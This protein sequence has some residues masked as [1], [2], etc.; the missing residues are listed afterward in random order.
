MI[1]PCTPSPVPLYE[2]T[3]QD[4]ATTSSSYE[5]LVAQCHRLVLD[6]IGFVLP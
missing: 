4:C 5:R 2:R 1:A 6:V 3:A